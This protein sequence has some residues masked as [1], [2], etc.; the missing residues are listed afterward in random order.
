MFNRNSFTSTILLLAVVLA[1]TACEKEN[2]SPAT[3]SLLSSES[4]SLATDLDLNAEFRSEEDDPSN[5]KGL[6]DCF[7]IVYPVTVIS[8]DSSTTEAADAEAVKQI[9]ADWRTNNPDSRQRP[10]IAFPYDLEL[11]DGTITTVED[12]G[13]LQEVLRACA[14]DIVTGD[15]RCYTLVYPVTIKLPTGREIVVD[16]ARERALVYRN[17]ERANPDSRRR[18]VLVFPYD[19]ELPNGDIVT[20][21][22]AEQL[23]RLLQACKDNRP[24]DNEPCFTIIYPVDLN[25][26]DGTSLEV[27]D[28]Q[29][30]GQLIRRWKAANPDATE[31]P[32]I[33][34]PYD[35]ELANGN[36]ATISSQEE[37]DRL[38]ASC[39]DDRPV[40]DQKC[41]SIVF[42]VQVQIPGA[43]AVT[44]DNAIALRRLFARWEKANP[45]SQRK[46]QL[47]FPYDVER[48]DGTIVTIESTEQLRRLVAS[49]E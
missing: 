33:A 18:P 31:F 12:R 4:T 17:W 27:A 25:F 24:N 10:R 38:K 1:F 9:I 48:N 7:T 47:V 44:V 30:L 34:F 11:S 32:Q 16:N 3:D 42:P 21:N 20:I 45:R 46:P 35:V 13:D 6:R 5:E 2:I 49:C 14:D 8:P 37:L 28:R 22:N 40:S 23:K 26:P 39:R 19:V 15:R 36:T 43:N 41:F 29:A